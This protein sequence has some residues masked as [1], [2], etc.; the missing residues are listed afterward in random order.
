[1]TPGVVEN[2]EAIWTA[3]AQNGPWALV[4]LLE[5]QV[6][7]VLWRR[8]DEVQEQRLTEKALVV[9]A[10]SESTQLTG[11][12]AELVARRKGGA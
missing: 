11:R 9:K 1:M 4:A 5:L 6:I 12:V 8:Y 7:R 10:I 2:S 3:V